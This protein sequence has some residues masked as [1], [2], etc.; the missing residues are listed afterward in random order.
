[1]STPPPPDETDSG[2]P[3]WA[4]V[5]PGLD[6][7]V[8]GVVDRLHLASRYLERL[9]AECAA[10]QGL[11]SADYEILARLYWVGPPHRLTPTQLAAG[12]LSPATTI[13]SRLERLQK[14]GLIIRAASANDRRS[15]PAELTDEGRRVF[16]SVVTE[17]A[18]R[19]RDA[20]SPMG[21]A[22]LGELEGLLRKL[23]HVLEQ[24]LGPAPRRVRLAEEAGKRQK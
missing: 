5:I 15:T 23:M 8:E 6:P 21:N 24:S 4:K 10:P 9:A 2:V 3:E 14:A 12:T 18:R 7:A 1:M 11:S 19:E 20:I 13:T 17:Q 22:E 16:L